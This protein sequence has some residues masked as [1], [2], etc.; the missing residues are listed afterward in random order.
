MPLL[1]RGSR[2]AGSGRVCVAVPG[3]LLPQL[4]G[5]GIEF[6]AG[7]AERFRVVPEHLFRGL[8]DALPQFID[9]GAGALLGG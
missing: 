3:D 9:A 4:L 7:E 2:V 1:A 5:Q 8:F 6:I